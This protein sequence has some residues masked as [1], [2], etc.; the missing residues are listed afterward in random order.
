MNF[1]KGLEIGDNHILITIRNLYMHS[2]AIISVNHLILLLNYTMRFLLNAFF[3]SC[4]TIYQQLT[5]FLK[6]Q[7]FCSTD[8]VF[9]HFP[10]VLSRFIICEQWYVSYY[11]YAKLHW[12]HNNRFHQPNSSVISLGLRFS[13][14]PR[15]I[16]ADNGPGHSQHISAHPILLYVGYIY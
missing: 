12:I 11:S 8:S 13:Y 4:F 5:E 9:F 16:V 1:L 2:F 7:F 6:H 10:T 14:F 3:I 15:A